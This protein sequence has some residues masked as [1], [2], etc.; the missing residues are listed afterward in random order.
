MSKGSNARPLS[1]DADTYA[2]R[3][4]AT[5]GAKP[6]GSSQEERKDGEATEVQHSQ[7]A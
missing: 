1:V 4:D 2:A 7:G 5:F 3:W 6:E